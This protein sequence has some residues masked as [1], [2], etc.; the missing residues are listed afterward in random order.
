MFG[1]NKN[2][3]VVPIMVGHLTESKQK[4]YA[5]IIKQV[6]DSRTLL[7]ISS[8]FCHWGDNFDYFY[9]ENNLNASNNSV[10]K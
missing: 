4:Y 3:T 8:D 2:F 6:I 7:L 5:S 1:G 10:S 9:L